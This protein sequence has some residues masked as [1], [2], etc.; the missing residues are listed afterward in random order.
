MGTGNQE[1]YQ[2]IL[3]DHELP[4]SFLFMLPDLGLHWQVYAGGTDIFKIF[5]TF[6]LKVE[7]GVPSDKIRLKLKSLL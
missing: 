3:H 7:V 4:S 6:S 5:L 1:R 2:N